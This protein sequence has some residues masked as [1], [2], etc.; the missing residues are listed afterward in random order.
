MVLEF[1]IAK[2]LINCRFAQIRSEVVSIKLGVIEIMRDL[3]GDNPAGN[4]N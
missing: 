3:I 1:V 4:C 2:I